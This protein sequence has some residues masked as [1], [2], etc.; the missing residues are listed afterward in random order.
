MLCSLYLIHV[1][2]RWYASLGCWKDTESSAV[3]SLEGSDPLLKDSYITR[4]KAID[5][6]A[7]VS[8]KHDFKGNKEDAK[9]ITKLRSN[10]MR[11]QN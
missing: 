5:T 3:S 7:Q 4:E 10:Q 6:C 1:E 11:I 2:N 8:R 9:Y